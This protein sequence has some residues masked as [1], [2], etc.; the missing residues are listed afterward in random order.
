MLV[1]GILEKRWE[2]IE[3]KIE[4]AY[5]RSQYVG[6]IKKIQIDICDG[7]YVKNNTWSPVINSAENKI[8][9]N[10]LIERG[11]PHWEDFHYEADL[12]VSDL[13]S[14]IEKISELGF[15]FVILHT[16]DLEYMKEMVAYANSYMLS[17]GIA[18]RDIGV[19][20]SYL[21]FIKENKDCDIDF[22]QI[23]GIKEIGRQGEAFDEGTIENIKLIK[24]K[25]SSMNDNINMSDKIKIQID[26]AMN[27]YTIELCMA[28][29][30][31]D[32][33]QGS[34]YFKIHE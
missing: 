14:H 30:A 5:N 1:P 29:G 21:D 4:V 28:A 7:I 3:D 16:E 19:I 13:K 25:I 33:V 26:G 18:S 11:L 12:M 10:T 9:I 17:V 24:D 23:M 8:L 31:T 34:A 32:F 2:Y 20:V 22:V 15:S 6:D 27:D